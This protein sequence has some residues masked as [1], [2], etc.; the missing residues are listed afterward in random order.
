MNIE[1]IMEIADELGSDKGIVDY[2]QIP[3]IDIYMDQLTTFIDNKLAG[4]KRED[5]EKILTKTMINNY[6]KD[7]LLPPPYKKKYTAEHVALLIM[8]YHLKE[9]LKISDISALFSS[10]DEVSFK[11]MYEMFTKIQE[12]CLE[13]AKSEIKEIVRQLDQSEYDD[14]TAN[15]L[16]IMVL[17]LDSAYKSRLASRLID[18]FLREEAPKSKETSQKSNK[19]KTK[20]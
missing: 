5:N 20:S 11:A 14:K 6:C 3:E 8:I 15:A 18:T 2:R 19:T 9:T 13:P 12:T 7:K 16:L 17:T 10:L 1:K 4:L